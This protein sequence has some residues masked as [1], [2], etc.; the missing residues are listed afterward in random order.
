MSHSL[1]N[2][3]FGGGQ[4]CQNLV[5]L[6]SL[7]LSHLPSTFNSILFNHQISLFSSFHQ[8]SIYINIIDSSPFH[9]GSVNV[10]FFLVSLV[11]PLSKMYFFCTFPLS[12][13]AFHIDIVA[14]LWFESIVYIVYIVYITKVITFVCRGSSPSKSIFLFSQISNLL[15]SF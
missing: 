10:K 5:T 3:T 7:F 14:E 4:E 1:T 13:F 9:K 6:S 12:L 15:L 11:K 2:Q 8:Y